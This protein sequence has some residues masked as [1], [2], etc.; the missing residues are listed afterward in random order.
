MPRIREPFAFHKLS[1]D[2]IHS[3]QSR[4]LEN[5]YDFLFFHVYVFKGLFKLIK[6]KSHNHQNCHRFYI[7]SETCIGTVL[8]VLN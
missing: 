8:L 7:G 5:V 6:T 3:F 4:N 2:E 1:Q